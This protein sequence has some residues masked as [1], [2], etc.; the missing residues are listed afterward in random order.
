MRRLLPPLA[1]TRAIASCWAAF[2]RPTQPLFFYPSDRPDVTT[3]TIA[4]YWEARVPRDPSYR[5]IHRALVTG[6]STRF[7]CPAAEPGNHVRDV[8]SGCQPLCPTV[9]N[10]MFVLTTFMSATTNAPG[11]KGCHRK[12]VQIRTYVTSRRKG[13]QEWDR[14][15]GKRDDFGHKVWQAGELRTTY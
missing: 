8:C 2:G 3:R 10:F 14:K 5:R 1:P 12:C 6:P 7:R 15:L 11:H 9:T 4:V 13:C